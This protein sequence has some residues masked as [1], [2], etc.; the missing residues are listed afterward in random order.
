MGGCRK[1]FGFGYNKLFLKALYC[2]FKLTQ[3]STMFKLKLKLNFLSD[4][5]TFSAGVV[6]GG[7]VLKM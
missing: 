5:K 6:G 3:L 7:A 2:L 4:F 1:S